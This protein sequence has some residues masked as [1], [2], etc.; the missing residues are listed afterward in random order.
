MFIDNIIKMNV[1]TY[2]KK[3]YILKI[4]YSKIYNEIYIPIGT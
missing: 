1:G 3:K 4:S 2:I